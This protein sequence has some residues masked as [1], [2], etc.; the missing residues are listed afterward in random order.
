MSLTPQNMESREGLFSHSMYRDIARMDAEQ[1]D[2]YVRM[3]FTGKT[4]TNFLPEPFW[5]YWFDMEKHGGPGMD[6]RTPPSPAYF[7]SGMHN[8]IAGTKAG[9]FTVGDKGEEQPNFEFRSTYRAV[10]R[11]LLDEC[12]DI[13]DKPTDEQKRLASYA[14]EAVRRLQPTESFNRNYQER[15]STI[16]GSKE[17]VPIALDYPV[18]LSADLET[19]SIELPTMLEKAQ[20][21]ISEGRFGSL[22]LRYSSY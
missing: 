11:G 3:A 10:I 2:K 22:Q 16:R 17:V 12:S 14:V 7:L 8:T 9:T 5:N 20:T 21:L 1:L 6:G 19:L 18:E 4:D 15:V 13:T